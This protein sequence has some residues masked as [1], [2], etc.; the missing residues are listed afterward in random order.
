M[1]NIFFS[2][3]SDV[4]YI[5]SFGK[6]ELYICRRFVYCWA[7]DTFLIMCNIMSNISMLTSTCY[8]WPRHVLTKFL[9]IGS[10]T[11]AGS[12]WSSCKVHK[13]TADETAEV[14]GKE[15]KHGQSRK[16]KLEY[17]K[18]D[19]DELWSMGTPHQH[20][21]VRIGSQGQSR[22]R[23][24]LPWLSAAVQ[25]DCSNAQWRGSRGCLR[26]LLCC[27]QQC[28]P[29]HPFRGMST[30]PIYCTHNWLSYSNL[31]QEICSIIIQ[32]AGNELSYH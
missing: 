18:R 31:F 23:I 16:P 8:N 22:Y 14:E 11:I 2:L 24:E 10:R 17:E 25:R 26:Q 1:N 21:P 5:T 3:F 32:L 15:R 27:W 12:T 29:H 13:G 7:A 20:S 19:G 6:I 4:I 28:F 30:N 9:C